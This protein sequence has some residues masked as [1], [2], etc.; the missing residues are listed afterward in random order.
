MRVLNAGKTGLQQKFCMIPGKNKR[1]KLETKSCI[2]MQNE[3]L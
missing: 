1:K 3:K 2:N